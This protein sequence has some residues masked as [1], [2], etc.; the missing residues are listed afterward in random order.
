MQKINFSNYEHLS[1]IGGA[2]TNFLNKLLKIVNEVA[3][4]KDIQLKYNMQEFFDKE[5][6][7]LIQAQEKLF[8]K[9][10]K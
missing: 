4:S 1:C 2:Y 7:E 9:F 10:K 3:P 6:A 5:I 8:L